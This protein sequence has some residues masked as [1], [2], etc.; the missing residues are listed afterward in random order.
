MVPI[1]DL[2]AGKRFSECNRDDIR[3]IDLAL[4]VGYWISITS[5]NS[6]RLV[7]DSLEQSA[8]VVRI[9]WEQWLCE[10]GLD[11]LR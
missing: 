7:M 1:F 8:L 5:E 3:A 2:D 9:R 11:N 6:A 4:S 10:W